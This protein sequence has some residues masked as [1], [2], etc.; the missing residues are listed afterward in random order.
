MSSPH[1]QDTPHDQNI[2][3]DQ[4][5]PPPVQH[6][7]ITGIP[8]LWQILGSLVGTAIFI[9]STLGA[10]GAWY[11]N[12][13]LESSQARL[14][15][16][17][18]KALTPFNERQTEFRMIVSSLVTAS[19]LSPEQKQFYNNILTKVTAKDV[20]EMLN[21]QPASAEKRSLNQLIR[22]KQVE[23]I[24]KVTGLIWNGDK[25]A[26][27]RIIK[28]NNPDLNLNKIDLVSD[29]DSSPCSSKLFLS[30]EV[31]SAT[32]QICEAHLDSEGALEVII[33]KEPDSKSG[34]ASITK[35]IHP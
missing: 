24:G 33:V 23:Q 11:L 35:Q 9:I 8:P 32:V 34:A 18:T 26:R 29:P 30:S 14:N 20:K 1:D 13:S 5:P 3:H 15:E 19:T 31:A 25:P 12:K 4:V 10:A 7:K 28:L 21:V 27:V 22:E 17:L 16:S 2:P 6:V